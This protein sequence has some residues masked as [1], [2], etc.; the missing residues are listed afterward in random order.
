MLS[1]SR[2]IPIP[3]NYS[4]RHQTQ[5]QTQPDS[6]EATTHAVT[7]GE[8]IGDL[9]ED[10]SY[11]ESKIWQVKGGAGCAAVEKGVVVITVL[12]GYKCILESGTYFGL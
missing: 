7:R 11:T 1:S 9:P 12:V 3:R 8:A 10:T 2:T 4:Y 5:P 6:F